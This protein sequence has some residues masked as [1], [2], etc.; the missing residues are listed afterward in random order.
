M[1]VRARVT[2]TVWV[3]VSVLECVYVC[4]YVCACHHPYSLDFNPP[5]AENTTKLIAD[6][7]LCH[8]L[9]PNCLP[10]IKNIQSFFLFVLF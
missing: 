3:W 1:C 10:V 4:M 9:F 8:Q 6:Y 5:V 2:V 7:S